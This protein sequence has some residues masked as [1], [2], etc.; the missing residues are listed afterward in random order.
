MDGSPDS[1]LGLVWIP[2]LACADFASSCSGVS[3]AELILTESKTPDWSLKTKL[4][5]APGNAGKSSLDIWNS[6]CSDGCFTIPTV[7]RER[8]VVDTVGP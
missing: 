1:P 5:G 7:M 3:C 2:F 6:E 4:A 8:S